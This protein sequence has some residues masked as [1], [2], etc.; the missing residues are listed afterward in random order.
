MCMLTRSQ[1]KCVRG[2]PGHG[3]MVAVLGMCV[4]LGVVPASFAD[5]GLT[6]GMSISAVERQVGP[7]S[8]EEEVTAMWPGLQ[9][10][11]EKRVTRAAD[12]DWNMHYFLDGR[13]ITYEQ[14]ERL[15]GGTGR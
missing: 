5:T 6:S 11:T 2:F 10:Q 1:L 14:L 8:P 15:Y 9:K 4:L 3:C 13:Y 12:R 7:L